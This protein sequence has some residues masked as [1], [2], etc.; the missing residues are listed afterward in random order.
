MAGRA[1]GVDLGTLNSCVAVVDEGK[2]VVLADESRTTIPSCVAIQGGRELVGAAAKRHAVT[3]P[4][5]TILAVKRLIGHPF[6]SDEV[7]AAGARLPYALK[8]SPLG[9]VL[10]E[11][12]G[13]ELTPVQV[14]AKILQRVREVAEHNLGEPVKQAVISVPAHF[15]DVQRKATK[16]AAEYAGL[17]VLRLINEPT[18]AA[19]AYGYKKHKDFTLAVYDLGG[20]TF[21][22]T[23]MRARGD[24]F[25]VVATDGDSYLGGEDFDYAIA[26]WL[27]REFKIEFGR[28][29]SGDPSARLRLKEAAEKAK[30]ELSDVDSARIQLPFLTRMPDGTRPNFERALT[31]AKMAE[32]CQPLVE[33][34]L[35]LCERC[36]TTARVVRGEI[37]EVLLVGGQSRM[38][39]VREAVKK[40][41]AKE[42]RRDINPDEV[43]AMGA[44]LYAYSLTADSLK[45]EAVDAAE[46]AYAVAL[47]ETAVARKILDEVEQIRARPLDDQGLAARLASLLKAT[48]GDG[49]V[50]QEFAD[51]TDGGPIST[52]GP[53]TFGVTDEPGQAARPLTVAPATAGKTAIKTKGPKTAPKTAAP[54]TAAPKPGAPKTAAPKAKSEPTPSAP[55]PVAAA[56]GPKTK[57]RTTAKKKKAPSEFSELIERGAVADDDLPSAVKGLKDELLQIDYK[58]AELIEKLADELPTGAAAELLDIAKERLSD[59]LLAAKG[60]QQEVVANLKSAAE[61][62][63]ARRVDL[64]DV[65]SLP[66]GIAAV[67]DIFTVLIDQNVVV[68]TEHQRVFTTNQDGQA[69]VEIRVFQGRS[70][71]IHD[72]QLLGSFILEG[73]APARRMEPKIEVAF[74]IDE[75]GI[76]AV[77]A[78]DAESGAQQ[79][80]RIE[81][82]LGLQRSRRR[83]RPTPKRPRPK[84]RSS[85]SSRGDR[86]LARRAHASGAALLAQLARGMAP[87]VVLA[88]EALRFLELDR[89]CGEHERLGQHA[90]PRRQAE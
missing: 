62:K 20:G 49:P 4:Q 6:D 9:S 70:K 27:E 89:E 39:A 26:E 82:P 74:R 54:K 42:P 21:D 86:A 43:V 24:T 61:H 50:P 73:I 40:F 36:I 69:E 33:R 18:A 56:P 60:A 17:E 72:N 75:N 77:R 14:S 30:V 16:L 44:A 67:G 34:T 5:N 65:T 48:E 32:L 79:G 7:R 2:A 15:N 66:L 28:D 38:L 85:S 51:R 11:V 84:L 46:D 47:R 19:F 23:I 59:S 81:D 35:V 3:S 45:E 41:F 63:S 80:L 29:L 88:R 25:E 53:I 12:G 55:A 8:A 64:R 76:L 90:G 37:G 58:A 52:L 78:R 13:V 83:R 71:A 68:P 22:V 57:T 1:I 10:F 87:G 31:R